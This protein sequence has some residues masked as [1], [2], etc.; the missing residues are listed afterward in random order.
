MVVVFIVVVIGFI[1]FGLVGQDFMP[2]Y[3]LLNDT[4]S[5]IY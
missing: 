5:F 4:I 2:T 1:V 3:D